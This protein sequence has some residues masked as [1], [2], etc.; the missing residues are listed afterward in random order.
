MAVRWPWRRGLSVHKDKLVFTYQTTHLASIG[1][2]EIVH[3]SRGEKISNDLHQQRN[4]WHDRRPDG[5]DAGGPGDNDLALR[6]AE[7]ALRPLR[8]SE[9]LATIDGAYYIERV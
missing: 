8:M 2:A 6:P 7:G 9:M 1:A 4:L 5:P 3:G